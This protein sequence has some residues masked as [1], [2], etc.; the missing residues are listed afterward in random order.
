MITGSMLKC[1]HNGR[2]HEALSR[3]VS[4][5]ED[6]KFKLNSQDV[7]IRWKK[8]FFVSDEMTLTNRNRFS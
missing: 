7:S 3:K 4:L 6:V 5:Q 8:I 1:N 2:L